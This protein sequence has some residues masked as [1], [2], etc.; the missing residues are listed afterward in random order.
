M[1]NLSNS[2]TNG[3]EG[4]YDVLYL[5]TDA[6]RMAHNATHVPF[7]DWCPICGA[8]RGRSSPHRRVVVNKTAD[9]LPK[10]QTDYMFIRTVAESKTQ[11]CITFVETRSGVVISFMCAR[12]GGYE[13]LKKEI[14]RHFETYGFVNPVIIQ[15]DKEM[16]I[17]DVCRKVARERNA[18]TVLRFAPK[19]SHQSNGFV[20]AVHGHIQGLARCYQT[21][22]ETNTGVQLSRYAGFL[23]SRFTMRPDGRTPFQYLLGTPCVSPLCM[24]VESAFALIPAHEVRAA[25]LTN[26]WISGSWWGSDEHLVGTK[27]GLLKCRSVRRKPPGEQWS[28]RETIEARDTKWNFDVE[29][30]SGIPGP[31]LVPRRDEG[32]PTG[33]AP[34]EIPTVPPSAPPP[35]RHAFEMQ[36]H[37]NSGGGDVAAKTKMVICDPSCM[38]PVK[39]MVIGQVVRYTNILETPITELLNEDDKSID[40]GQIILAQKLLVFKNDIDAT[41]ASWRQLVTSVDRYITI[42]RPQRIHS[43]TDCQTR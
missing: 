41:M 13:D 29:M 8:S 19:T 11:P 15:S 36:V 27:H 38:N 35:E 39:M 43:E 9:T 6:A 7:R 26:R 20:E 30:D 16:S 23:L 14:L 22:I 33:A 12:K 1:E 24:F 40:T 42:V 37:S 18:R 32:M 34:M 3:C 21:Q 31:T 4:T 17:I 2:A 25:K 5:P 28:R 10:F